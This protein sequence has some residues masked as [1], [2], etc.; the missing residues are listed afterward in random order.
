M[1]QG[2]KVE[3]QKR[4][5]LER[6]YAW[7]CERLY[8]ELAWSYDLVSWVVSGGRWSRWREAS[9][10]YMR[11]MQTGRTLELGFGTGELLITLAQKADH[12]LYGLE[13][14]SAMHQVTD[15]KLKCQ[16]LAVPRV[17][18]SAQ[19]IPYAT[20]SFDTIISTFPAPYILD[21]STLQECRRV[22]AP[23]GRL[24][25]VGLWT[26]IDY[27]WLQELPLFYGKPTKEMRDAVCQRLAQANLHAEFLMHE[28]G[29]MQVSIV[30]AKADA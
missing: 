3:N 8:H 12:K 6:A 27:P 23:D 18:A 11:K 2:R 9:L 14:S 1:N 30:V 26:T 22:L 15:K 7:A 25:I 10:L 13:L 29:R 28:D 19:N 17:R 24:I 5:W 20:A 16:Q 4:S 21:R